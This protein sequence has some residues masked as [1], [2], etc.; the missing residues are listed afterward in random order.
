MI[1]EL[2]IGSKVEGQV[3]ALQKTSI[4]DK[5]GTMDFFFNEDLSRM[6][7]RA[8]LIT[9]VVK[10]GKDRRPVMFIKSISLA[11]RGTYN[12]ADIFVCLS[13]EKVQEYK[14]GLLDNLKYIKVEGYRKLVGF[15]LN[16]LNLEKLSRLPASIGSYGRYRGGALASCANVTKMAIDMGSTYVLMSNEMY[17]RNI[18]WSVLLCAAM[19]S[20]YGMISYCT[21][22]EPFEKT[23]IGVER[24]YTSLLISELEKAN[25]QNNFLTD[26]Q[27]ARLVNVICTAAGRISQKSGICPTSKEGLILSNAIVAYRDLDMFDFEASRVEEDKPY[28]FSKATNRYIGGQ[29]V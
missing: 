25:W 11:K 22:E 14:K 2:N 20:S 7:G 24:G 28:A 12:P 23:P 4:A 10:P 15:C 16:D 26:E 5:S 19:L 1:R 29:A 18:D 27:M 8:V 9:G 3:F 17:S 13:P 6:V 21:D